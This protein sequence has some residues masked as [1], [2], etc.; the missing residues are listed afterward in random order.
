M[1]ISPTLVPADDDGSPRMVTLFRGSQEVS[2]IGA[3]D[4]ED[5]AKQAAIMVLQQEGGLRVGDEVRISRI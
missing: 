2:A 4:G 3:A 5:A 1:P